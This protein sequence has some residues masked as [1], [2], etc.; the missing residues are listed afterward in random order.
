MGRYLF[1]VFFFISLIFYPT[2]LFSH[3]SPEAPEG[4]GAVAPG[5]GVSKPGAS[6]HHGTCEEQQTYMSKGTNEECFVYKGCSRQGVKLHEHT[7]VK[8]LGG[9]GPCGPWELK[10][11]VEVKNR[12]ETANDSS[13]TLESS[14][15][16][17]EA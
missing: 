13:L 3:L 4:K 14:R 2:L 1:I 10:N 11:R 7:R 16:G 6:V 15:S 8:H 9:G 17:H 12:K 5:I